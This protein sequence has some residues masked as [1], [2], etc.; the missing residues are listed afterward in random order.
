MVQQRGEWRSGVGY[1]FIG[2][3]TIFA[4]AIEI[5]NGLI[6]VFSPWLYH[7]SYTHTYNDD[8]TGDAAPIPTRPIMDKFNA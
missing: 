7:T 4:P 1:G 8:F 3:V 5:R 2:R 6:S